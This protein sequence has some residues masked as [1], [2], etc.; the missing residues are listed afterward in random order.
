MV[1]SLAVYARERRRAYAAEAG[2]ED[3]VQALT[4]LADERDD[5]L[6]GGCTC[7]DGQDGEEEH[8]W[9]R[10]AF[11]LTPARVSDGLEGSQ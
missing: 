1:I 8:V 6:V 9:K 2:T 5:A 3:L 11:A 10:V 7:Q 4:V